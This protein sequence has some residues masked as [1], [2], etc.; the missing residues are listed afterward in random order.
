LKLTSQTRGVVWQPG[1]TVTSK[2]VDI[3][4]FMADGASLPCFA[5]SSAV[6]LDRAS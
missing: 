2:R 6:S 1:S 3:L 4:V 5:Y